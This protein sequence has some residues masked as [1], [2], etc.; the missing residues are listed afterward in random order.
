MARYVDNCILVLLEHSLGKEQNV[1]F[2]YNHELYI[3]YEGFQVKQKPIIE[4]HLYSNPLGFA[5]RRLP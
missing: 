5:Q 3:E 2:N 4:S 1:Q